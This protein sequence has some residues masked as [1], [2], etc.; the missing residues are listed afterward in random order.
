ML[1]VGLW[2][3]VPSFIT[4]LAST[5]S[6]LLES[7]V[8]IF[9]VSVVALLIAIIPRISDKNPRISDKN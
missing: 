1:K 2:V 9:I 7:I 8:F 3:G 6:A 4:Y 5:Y